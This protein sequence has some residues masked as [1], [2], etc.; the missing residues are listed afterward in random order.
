[1][2]SSL[3]SPFLDV[4]WR[5]LVPPDAHE[6]APGFCW[7]RTRLCVNIFPDRVC[8]VTGFAL[9]LSPRMCV[10]LNYMP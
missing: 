6:C 8:S 2:A 10:D 7:R 9:P 5:D 3:R 4:P 1:M